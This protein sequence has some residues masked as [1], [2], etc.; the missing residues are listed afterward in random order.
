MA[1]IHGALN[2]RAF[3]VGL[4]IALFLMVLSCSKST[5]PGDDGG[6]QQSGRLNG[7]AADNAV[8]Q[9]RSYIDIVPSVVL[10][11]STSLLANK[12]SA[13]L[14]P[15]TTVGQV[16]SLL[17]SLTAS[18]I[19]MDDS[20]VFLALSIPAVGD[21]AVLDSIVSRLAQS[22]PFL[23][24]FPCFIPAPP[25][26]AD[27][28]PAPAGKIIPGSPADQ[29][30]A[31]LKACYMPAA[32]NTMD[33]A[34]ALN[35]QVTVLVPD[36][37]GQLS[38]H[39]E[40]P[41]Q[42]FVSIPGDGADIRVIDG[43]AVGNHGFYVS[44]ILGAAFDDNGVTGL[45]PG[46]SSLIKIRSLNIG[47]DEW[48]IKL[49]HMAN[50]IP[51]ASPTLVSTSFGY[52][53]PTFTKVSKW[54]R[55]L[56]ALKWREL[57]GAHQSQFL[58]LSSSGND[59]RRTDEGSLAIFNNPFTMAALMV[60]PW[61]W[62]G[63]G[64]Y[65]VADSLGY[66]QLH[67]LYGTTKPYILQPLTNVL[68]VGSSRLN[69]TRSAFSNA[70]ANIR[71]VGETVFAPCITDD[72]TCHDDFAT[73]SGTSMATPQAAGLAA[74]L[75]NLRPDL[76]PMQAK[77]ILLNSY[78]NSAGIVNAY[79]AVLSL[80]HGLDD[81]AVRQSI[82]NVA[83]ETSSTSPVFDEEDLLTFFS[84]ADPPS[85]F[86][87]FDPYDLNGDG[88]T[89]GSRTAPFDLT[90]DNP[91]DYTTLIMP[92]CS[93]DDTL[94]ESALTDT[95][96]LKFYAYSDLYIGDVD[97]RDSLFDETCSPHWTGHDSTMVHVLSSIP[98]LGISDWDTSFGGSL[99]VEL[100]ESSDSLSPTCTTSVAPGFQWKWKGGG[101]SSVTAEVSS[102]SVSVTGQVSLVSRAEAS[103][104]A[105]PAPC[106]F[107]VGGL[108]NAFSAV[109]FAIDESTNLLTGT[110]VISG[111]VVQPDDWTGGDSPPATCIVRIVTYDTTGIRAAV[112]SQP[113]YITFDTRLNSLPF[114]VDLFLS[115]LA[116]NNVYRVEIE[117]YTRG[118]ANT[119]SEPGLSEA[120]LDINVALFA[121]S[122]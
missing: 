47:T 56:L 70:G 114:Q 8:G 69:G 65:S 24:A 108:G 14:S 71:F 122:K 104:P 23:F 102:S 96:I 92:F 115:P 113:A 64:E 37:Y 54:D 94:N 35:H 83:G 45:H 43:S 40:I 112:A 41:G 60:S 48:G 85:P 38:P 49:H 75:M 99:V 103:G 10:E 19:C 97:I 121:G 36:A 9:T 1:I 4:S 93:G 61:D 31:H 51:A 34:E 72:V 116:P 119:Q 15:S 77:Q 57:I 50:A 78:D 44:G 87:N 27:P 5:D 3:V 13:I 89:G 111:S 107:G 110:L 46:S 95:D 74:Y 76:T 21:R 29:N 80:D 30:I 79:K 52:N 109:E 73:P 105:Q 17:D 67:E 62:L 55:I 91:P 25:V 118:L 7:D 39:A 26:S 42:E 86:R 117:S 33:F 58:H 16:N 90:A 82:L 66:E 22:D 106:D 98:I 18:I 88:Y 101:T 120:K 81:A 63:E 2:L 32:W 28:D 12:V 53:D 84:G 6:G 20:S 59:G 11:D 100:D 68:I